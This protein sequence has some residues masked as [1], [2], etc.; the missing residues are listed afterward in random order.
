MTQA[1]EQA[2]KDHSSSHPARDVDEVC[3]RILAEYCQSY[4]SSGAA[5]LMRRLGF[6]YKMPRLL[7]VVRRQR[8][9]DSFDVFVSEDFW[10]IVANMERI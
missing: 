5:K 9:W 7:S 2:V 4:S 3:A 6:E 10:F 1:Q 8:L